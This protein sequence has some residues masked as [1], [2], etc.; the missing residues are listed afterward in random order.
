MA[1][2]F[3]IHKDLSGIHWVRSENCAQDLCAAASYQTAQSQYFS[4]I[5]LEADVINTSPD[6]QA[7]YIKQWLQSS[8]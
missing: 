6:G 5:N 2:P 7:A 4:R 8:V 1:I 3:S